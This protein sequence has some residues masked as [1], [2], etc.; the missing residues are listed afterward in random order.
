MRLA[1]IGCGAIAQYMTWFA[2]LN[3]N[4]RLV[5]ACDRSAA[6]V[7]TFARRFRIPHT[8]TDY[9]VMLAETELDAVYLATPHHLHYEMLE[10]AIHHHIPV[11]T[12]KPITR[13]LAEGEAIVRHAAAH[14]V[15]IGV[16]YQYR[17]DTGCYQLAR[18]VQN[19]ALG[20]IHSARI[21]VPWHRQADYFEQAPWH[22]RVVTAGGGT[23]ITQ[24]SHFLDVV[25][26]ALEG[27]TPQTALGYTAQRQFKTMKGDGPEQAIDVE[28]LAQGVV[29]MASGALIQ[30]CSSMVASSEQAVQIEM[31]GD[32]GT[33][34]YSSSPWPRVSFRD[35]RGP[36]YRPPQ[37]GF[38]A[39]Q[40]SLE[41]FRAWVM[42]DTPYLIPSAAALP[43]LSVVEAIYRS[44]HTGQ[45]EAV[46]GVSASGS[47]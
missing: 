34:V 9:T 26:W 43:A 11:F 3:R 46:P 36:R 19:G 5:A 21:N 30:I 12:E 4:I 20:T 1:I 28:D 22:S 8:F 40:R 24:G 39:L 32:K 6:K 44:A 10:A 47:S 41:G 27:D 14:G 35:V 45:R 38:H 18:A 37:R 25:L 42:A 23:L 2:R 31:Y 17:Y 16:N 29:A 13:T 15:K 7:E 33:A